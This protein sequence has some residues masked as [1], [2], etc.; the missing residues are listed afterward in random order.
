MLTREEIQAT[1]LDLSI[2]IEDLEE[3]EKT[4]GRR[5]TTHNAAID[6]RVSR[7]KLIDIRHRLAHAMSVPFPDEPPE[8][9][10]APHVTIHRFED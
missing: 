7:M 3:T 1:D 8:P 6:I 5:S 4:L 2:A 10:E 9:P